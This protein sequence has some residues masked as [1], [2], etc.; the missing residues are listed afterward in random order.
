[1]LLTVI[2]SQPVPCNYFITSM[3]LQNVAKAR[4]GPIGTTKLRFTAVQ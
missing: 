2:A 1:M 3:L 4:N